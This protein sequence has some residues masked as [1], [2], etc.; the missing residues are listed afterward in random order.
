MCRATA[1]NSLTIDLSSI[2][3]FTDFDGDTV[4]LSNDSKFTVQ[5]DIP[6]LSTASVSA[7]VEEDDL[8]NA[9]SVGSNEDASVGKTVATGSLTTLL[10]VCSDE[11]GT[12]PLDTTF[13]SLTSQGLTSH[14]VALSYSVSGDTLTAKAGAPTVFTLQVTAGGDYTFTLVDQLYDVSGSG[15]STVPSTCRRLFAS[16]ISTAIPFRFPTISKSPCRTTFR[17]CRRLRCR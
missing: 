2:V 15:E 10:S 8:N 1:E 14:N 12:F 3:R 17:S 9:Q 5:D 13:A 16:P 4:S 11:P 7:T 6:V